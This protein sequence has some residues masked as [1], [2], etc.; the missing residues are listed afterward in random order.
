MQYT[1]HT[2]YIPSRIMHIINHMETFIDLNAPEGIMT[3]NGVSICGLNS[4]SD[5]TRIPYKA[6]NNVLIIYWYITRCSLKRMNAF[7]IVYFHIFILYYFMYISFV[8]F[9][10]CQT[11]QYSL[12][13]I[14]I[15]K[16]ICKRAIKIVH[17]K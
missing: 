2:K 8:V 1:L 15:I 5:C 17:I 16:I 6:T 12:Q 7:L 13:L 9:S 3:I 14:C 11:T 10:K 4:S